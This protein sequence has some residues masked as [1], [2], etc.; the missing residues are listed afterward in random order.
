MCDWLSRPAAI[1]QVILSGAYPR[2]TI[3]TGKNDNSP[4]LYLDIRPYS[5]RGRAADL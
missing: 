1:P 4:V 3:R 5:C 2:A